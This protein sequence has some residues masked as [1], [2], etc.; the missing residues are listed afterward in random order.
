M[1]KRYILSQAQDGSYM[2]R[3]TSINGYFES[4]KYYGISD[5]NKALEITKKLNA[6]L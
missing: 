2:I 6:G 5:Y 1:S 3:D 4:Q